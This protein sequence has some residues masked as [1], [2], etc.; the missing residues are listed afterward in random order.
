VRALPV[1]LAATAAACGGTPPPPPKPT[2]PA[3]AQPCRVTKAEPAPR[4]VSAELAGTEAANGNGELWAIGLPPAGVLEIEP[5]DGSLDTKLAWWRRVKGDLHVTGERVDAPAAPL[6]AD[7]PAGYPET[8]FQPTGLTFP[9]QGCWK[10]TGRIGDG[11]ALRF[12]T[13]VVRR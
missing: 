3:G 9:T 6:R 7:V 5:Q 2:T 11:R 12:V 1:L 13:L 4:D 8:G 10:I